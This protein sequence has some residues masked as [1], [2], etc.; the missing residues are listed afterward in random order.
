MTRGAICLAIATGLCACSTS[1]VIQNTYANRNQ[2]AANLKQPGT[3]S[4][5]R[6]TYLLQSGRVFYPDGQPLV[7]DVLP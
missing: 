7:F 6:N 1:T 4:A 2:I 5:A 3:V